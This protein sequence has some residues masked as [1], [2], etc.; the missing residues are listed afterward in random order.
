LNRRLSTLEQK[1]DVEVHVDVYTGKRYS[2]CKRTKKSQWI[3]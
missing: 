2:Y 3:L 1:V